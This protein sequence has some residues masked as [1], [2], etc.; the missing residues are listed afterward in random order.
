MRSGIQK[1]VLA[2]YRA[3]MRLTTQHAA[4]ARG[5]LQAKIRAEFRQNAALKPFDQRVE[6]LLG[7]AHRAELML[8]TPGF[9]GLARQ[10]QIKV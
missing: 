4:P 7:R 2:Q 3:L 1:Q 9:S 10:M 5:E 6:L 8:A